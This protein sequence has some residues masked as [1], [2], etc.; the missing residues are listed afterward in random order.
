MQAHIQGA[1]SDEVPDALFA[2]EV[3]TAAQRKDAGLRFLFLKELICRISVFGNTLQSS[4]VSLRCRETAQERV[5]DSDAAS[6]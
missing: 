2:G 3:G 6:R 5:Q 4:P 1:A